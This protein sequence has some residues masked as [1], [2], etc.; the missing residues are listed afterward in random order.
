[1]PSVRSAT[2]LELARREVILTQS[3]CSMPYCAA[4]SGL[5]RSSGAGMSSRMNGAWRIVPW[6]KCGRRP[7]VMTSGYSESVS[8]L[9]VGSWNVHTGS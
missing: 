7:V 8:G 3:P 6:W 5:M 9:S 4:V 2:A 1:M